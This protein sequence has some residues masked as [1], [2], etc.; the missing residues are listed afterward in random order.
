MKDKP[1]TEK[2][3]HT[4]PFCDKAIAEAAFPYCE[5]CGLKVLNCPKCGLAVP[6]HYKKCP[7]CGADMKNVVIKGA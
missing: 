7:H 6:R 1:E 2:K 4:C 3:V 5:A